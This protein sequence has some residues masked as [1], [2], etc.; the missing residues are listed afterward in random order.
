MGAR[1]IADLMS[2]VCECFYRF[3]ILFHPFGNGKKGGLYIIFCKNFYKLF[4]VLVSPC[5][6]KAY[7]N[8]FALLLGA[9][10]RQKLF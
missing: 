1:M 3:G 10:Y 4:G 8:F 9:V 2:G 6:I 7:G 5:G